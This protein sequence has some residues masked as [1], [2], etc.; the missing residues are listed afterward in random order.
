V[1]VVVIGGGIVGASAAFH[2]VDGG[3]EVVVVD[4]DR[5]GRATRA[6]AGIVSASSR[7][8]SPGVP[9]FELAARAFAAY[10]PLISQL[11]ADHLATADGLWDVIGELHVAPAGPDLDGVYAGLM[12]R[13]DAPDDGTVAMLEPAATR[14]A[15]PYLRPDLASVR[16]TTTVRVDGEIVR[17]AL[18]TAAVRRGARVSVGPAT[19]VVSGGRAVGVAAGGRHEDADAVIVAAGAWSADVVRPAGVTLALDAQRGQILHLKLPGVDTSRLPVVHPVGASHYILPFADS[20]IVVGATR[21]T[22]SGF[23]P[24]LTAGGVAQVLTQALGVAPGLAGATI[25]E[26]R[27]GLRPATPDGDPLLG[28]VPSCPGL[29]IAT[30]MGPVGLSIGPYSGGLIA[31][32]VLGIEPEMDLIPFAPGRAFD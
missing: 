13:A 14:A 18:L 4:D 21:E 12:A 25:G 8:N 10:P 11:A 3:A 27:V 16:V 15:F 23:D 26:M 19:L 31:G 7:R 32:W 22:G 1:K 30:G 5:P 9:A 20:R 6:G 28:P 17:T 24:R 2:L 29:W